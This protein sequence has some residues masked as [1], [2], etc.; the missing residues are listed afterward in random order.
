MSKAL[1]I[2]PALLP[3]LAALCRVRYAEMPGIHADRILASDGVA[4][5]YLVAA[6]GQD[7]VGFGVLQIERP[8]R[9]DDPHGQ[10]PMVI[11]LFV[12][13][14]QRGQGYGRALLG[15]MEQLAAACGKAALHLSVEPLE[16]PRALAL[17]R[18]LGY[19]PL[20]DAPYHSQWRFT[21]SQGVEHS[22]AEWVID[23]RKPLDKS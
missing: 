14:A 19:A 2:R 13:A 17:Y 23:M 3:D 11:D 15:A 6:R 8:E 1:C 4:S 10:F 22:G 9:W 7:I 16:N 18:R 5:A 21:D 20:Q 12:D